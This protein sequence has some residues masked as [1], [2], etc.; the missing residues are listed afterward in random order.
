[1]TVGGEAAPKR[2]AVLGHPISHSMSPALHGAA[3]QA[4]GLDAT[5][6]AI[7]VEGGKLGEFIAGLGPEWMGL[8]LTMPHKQDAFA[9][10]DMVDGLAKEVGAI[11]TLVFQPTGASKMTIGFNT[12]VAGIV[13]AVREVSGELRTGPRAVIL[14]SRATASS[15]LAALVQLGAKDIAVAARSVAGP[16]TVVAAAHRMNVDIS[17]MKLDPEKV[18][19]KIASADVLISTLPSGIADPIAEALADV[20]CTGKLV[21]DVA[22]D[23]PSKLVAAVV[24]NG[25][26]SVPGWLMLLHQAA[27]QVRLFT[28]KPADVEVMRAALLEEMARRA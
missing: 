11:N 3:Y 17:T 25:G 20:D 4:L 6:E 10:C 24:A 1:M 14:G 5:Y 23:K 15:A 13:N 7:D 19:A 12:D 28:G 27:D 22:Y 18:A 8:S 16:G 21:L 9:A 2:A 26:V